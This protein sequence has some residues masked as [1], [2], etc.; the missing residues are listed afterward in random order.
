MWPSAGVFTHS[1]RRSPGRRWQRGTRRE[2]QVAPRREHRFAHRLV[3]SPRVGSR[4]CHMIELVWDADRSGTCMSSDGASLT[5]GDL[6]AWSPDDLLTMAA[7]SCLM[8]TFLQIAAKEHVPVLGYVAS[9]STN[10]SD[11][12]V[13][14]HAESCGGVE[15]ECE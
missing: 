9:A 8:R 15:G 7:A 5:A 3:L 14:V 2:S 11:S 13:A 10:T 1:A 12:G 6:A 4:E